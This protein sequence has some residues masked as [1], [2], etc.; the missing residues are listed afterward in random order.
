MAYGIGEAA[1]IVG[2][3]PTTVRVW[4]ADFGDFFSEFATPQ[5]GQTRAYTDRDIAILATIKELRSQQKSNEA[6]TSALVQGELVDV[7]HIE[8]SLAQTVGDG[9]STLITRLTAAIAKFEGELAATKE[10]L[11]RTRQEL[12]GER[13]A[14][15]AA[16]KEAARLAGKLEVLEAQSKQSSK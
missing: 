11:E 5:K 9:K 13:Q 12:A 15:I 1:K 10:A 7:S 14:R 4:T 6:I 2:V 3:S 16:E 8:S